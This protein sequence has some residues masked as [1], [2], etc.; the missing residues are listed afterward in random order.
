LQREGRPDDLQAALQWDAAVR[1]MKQDLARLGVPTDEE[2]RMLWLARAEASREP[3]GFFALANTLSGTLACRL[4]LAAGVIL[5]NRP[6]RAAQTSVMFAGALW[7]ITAFTLLLTK[8]RTAWVGL[9]AG[10][11]ALAGVLNRGGSKR[12]RVFL[13]GGAVA[14]VLVLLGIV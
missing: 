7:I 1:E 11:T 9:A 3:F 4:I 13:W 10:L 12:P 6:L 2:S 5:I 8:S 14:G